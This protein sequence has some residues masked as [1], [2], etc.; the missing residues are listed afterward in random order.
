M[1]ALIAFIPAAIIALCIAL[2]PVPLLQTL[3]PFS[4]SSRPPL[5]SLCYVD[6]HARGAGSRSG[7]C[8]EPVD[9]G[10]DEAE[11]A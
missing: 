3:A 10:Q 1:N 2:V 5:G 6:G 4:G 7:W 11:A 9:G 8:P